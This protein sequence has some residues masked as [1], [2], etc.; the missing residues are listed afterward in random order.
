MALEILINYI[1]QFISTI[2]YAGIF[3]L[4][5]LESMIA[6][7]PSEAV[8]PFAGFLVASGRFSFSNVIIISSIGS[9]VGSLVSYYLGYFGG[10]PLIKK[11]GKYLFLEEQHLDWTTHFF[12]KYGTA[13]IFVSRFIPV[14][15]H[16]ISIPAGY[17][18]MDIA[19][20]VIYTF[21]GAT[22]WNG[23]LTYVGLRLGENWDIIRSYTKILDIAVIGVI[24]LGLAVW[25]LLH[26][27]RK[28]VHKTG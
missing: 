22:L 14:V 28:A 2:G 13:T 19:Q 17:A 24:V 23:F 27:R 26:F 15:R 25:I 5:T 21:I 18:K 20:F 4:M 7:I 12:E 11:F 6:P 1:T 3:V 16:V 10:Q 9:I 8:M